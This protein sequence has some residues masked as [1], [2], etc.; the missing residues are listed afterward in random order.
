[1]RNVLLK[2]GPGIESRW[3]RDF[4]HLSRP[5]L[6]PIQLPVQWVPGLSWGKK[7]PG[8][9]AHPSP[10]LVP[11]SR[12]SWAIH[13]IPLWAVRPVQNLSACTSVH[14]YLYLLKFKIGSVCVRSVQTCRQTL[15]SKM[16]LRSTRP[17]VTRYIKRK[18]KNQLLYFPLINVFIHQK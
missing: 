18:Y 11:W 3:R 5:A 8:S 1:M 4:S 12:K 13:L 17:V 10:L 16:L 2:I 9:D 14:L 7:R 6:E 15:Q